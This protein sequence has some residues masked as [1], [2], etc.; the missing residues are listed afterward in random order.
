MHGDEYERGELDGDVGRKRA[1]ERVAEHQGGPIA[2]TIKP[3]RNGA[4]RLA[5]RRRMPLNRELLAIRWRHAGWMTLDN[6]LHVLRRPV[7]H[8][9]EIATAHMGDALVRQ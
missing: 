5:E 9:R 8:A 3:D 6:A 2:A 7:Q 1:S 4:H